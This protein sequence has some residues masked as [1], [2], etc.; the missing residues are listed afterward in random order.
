MRLIEATTI[1]PD[2]SLVSADRHPL[3]EAKRDEMAKRLIEA[4]KTHG[5]LE[6]P[7]GWI[8]GQVPTGGSRK[9]LTVG[10]L[11]ELGLGHL[12]KPPEPGVKH[13]WRMLVPKEKKRKG[14][15]A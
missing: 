1:E 3:D 9:G 2:L 6:S 5:P 14:R 12:V 11:E 13:E 4:R 10:E 7:D 15:A 8:Y